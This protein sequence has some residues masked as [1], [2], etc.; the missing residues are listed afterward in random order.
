MEQR[1]QHGK[2]G[3]SI[4]EDRALLLMVV[5]FEDEQGEIDWDMVRFHFPSKRTTHELKQ[6]LQAIKACNACVLNEFPDKF[7]AGSCLDRTRHMMTT[8]S[9]YQAVDDIFSSFTRADVR[10]PSGQRNFNTGE[11]APVGVTSFLELAH[12]SKTDV[13]VDIGSGIGTIVTQVALQSNVTS[14]IGLE[15]QPELSNKSRIVI[16]E[17]TRAYSRLNC[18]EIITGDVKKLPP[19]VSR[20]LTRATV[21]FANNVLFEPADNLGLRDYLCSLQNV[22]KVLV[23]DRLCHRC[24]PLCQNVFCEIF[25][26]S[27]SVDIKTCWKDQNQILFVYSLRKIR[28][29]GSLLDLVNQM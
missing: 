4:T 3:F 18:V 8:H 21:V 26:Q 6:R 22:K 7:F 19:D 12:L 23:T 20:K 25:T 5:V 10:Q 24:G 15:I 13:F 9:V 27:E 1:K 11:I 16:Q 29:E 28:L 2:L 14:S 17:A